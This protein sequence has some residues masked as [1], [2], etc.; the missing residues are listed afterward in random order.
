MNNV[1]TYRGYS[2]R[3]EY[4]PEDTALVGRVL[5]ITDII[6][7]HADGVAEFE[8][9]FHDAVDDYLES[10]EELGK[11]PHK[12]YSG[13][14]MFRID[15][16]LHREAAIAAELAGK[17]LNQ[18]AEDA[19]R[20]AASHPMADDDGNPYGLPITALDPEMVRRMAANTQAFHDIVKAQAALH[21]TVGLSVGVTPSQAASAIA[22]WQKEITNG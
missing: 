1:M 11:E 21:S 19:M 17:S 13:K 8:Q 12:P 9:M 3:V 22:A 14:V 5:G 16:E 6:M 10:C 2:T 4:S 18:W 7:F 20:Y 15:A